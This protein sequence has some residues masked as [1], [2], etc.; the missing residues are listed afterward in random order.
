M[1]MCGML[2]PSVPPP[3][4]SR[5]TLADTFE[6]IVFVWFGHACRGRRHVPRQDVLERFK[7]SHR[8]VIEWLPLARE[9]LRQLYRVAVEGR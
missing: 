1:T 7:V 8:A 6:G 4:L 2:T 9:M 3:A 5:P